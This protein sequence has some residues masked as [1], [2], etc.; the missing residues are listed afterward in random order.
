MNRFSSLDRIGNILI[1]I[2]TPIVL[3]GACFEFYNAAWGTG[4]IIGE[5]SLKWFIFFIA[6]ILL[7]LSALIWIFFLTLRAD[8]FLA[9]SKGL[10]SIRGALRFHWLIAS[11]VLILPVWFLQYSM[12]GV[13]FYGNY[14]RALIWILT[15]IIVSVLISKYDVLIGWKELLITLILTSSVFTIAIS[16]QGASNY[17]FSLGW[18]E[19]NRLWDYSTLFGHSLY[20]YP[21]DQKIPVL[22]D[23][24]RLLV[25][26]LPFLIPHLTIGMER[27]WVG[28][29]LIIPYFLVGLAAFVAADKNKIIWSLMILWVFL[30]LRQGPIHAPLVLAAALTIFVWRKSLWLGIPVMIFAGNFAVASRY[31]WLFAPAMWIGM[32]ELAGA[33]L[34]DGKLD[35]THWFRAI[36]LSFAGVFGGYLLPKLVPLL[37]HPA[38]NVVDLTEQIANAGVSSEFIANQVSAQPLLWYRLLPNSTYGD[39]ILVGLLI[40]VLPVLVILFWLAFSKKWKLNI[41]QKL[42]IIAP[43]L[44]FLVVGLIASA[45]IGGGGDLHN[46]DMF[47]IG[48]AF[49][50]FIAWLNGGRDALLDGASLPVWVK[51]A[52]VISLILPAIG[53]LQQMYPLRVSEDPSTLVT[54][55]DVPDVKSLDLLPS[56]D[57]IDGAL[58]K[59]RD[60]VA[61]ANGQG[62]VLFLDQRQLLTFG[63]VKDVPL[64]AEYEKKVLMNEALGGNADYFQS[65]YK[66]LAAHRFIMIVSER[67][68]TPIKDS[69]YQFGEENNAWVKWVTNPL[70][71][72]YQE[73][74][75]MKDFAI[76]LLI[77]RDPPKDCTKF[78]P[79]N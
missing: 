65:F 41:W 30:F 44:A 59:I 26:G 32:L 51:A 66:D 72:Y 2:V 48:L 38:N 33:S 13:V 39:G 8:K 56:Q 60:R 63:Y 47:L 54:L 29:T 77:P 76:E 45:K 71:C 5:F 74:G 55:A 79:Q 27:F 20:I 68:F 61:W 21:T 12:W 57:K 42:A 78:I 9:F 62:P 43:S 69:S 28:L 64:V 52:L 16:L 14:I 36:A 18:S 22:L 37:N 58:E 17:P 3:S 19:G 11:F 75:T 1:L 46:M 25:G 24:G 15:I 34:R 70:L 53:P 7:C 31:T 4:N 23:S 40:A 35:R 67:L 50:A 10:I 6:F 49:T 73:D